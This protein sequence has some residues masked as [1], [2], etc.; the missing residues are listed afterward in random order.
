MPIAGFSVNFS[1]VVDQEWTILRSFVCNRQVAC[2]PSTRSCSSQRGQ[3]LKGIGG[4]GGALV[5][6][7]CTRSVRQSDGQ[8]RKWIV[9][10]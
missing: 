10:D 9:R 8:L 6:N 4:G 5:G 7:G 2:S 1:A 3:K